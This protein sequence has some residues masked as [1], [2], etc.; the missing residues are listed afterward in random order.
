[1][2]GLDNGCVLPTTTL[3]T[4]MCH[5]IS[6][7]CGEWPSEPWK[8]KSQAGLDLKRLRNDVHPMIESSDGTLVSW[9]FVQKLGCSYVQI[10]PFGL[11]RLSHADH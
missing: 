6:V 4:L 7:L 5:L 9:I 3:H 1:M 10:Q 11:N 2:H 8:H